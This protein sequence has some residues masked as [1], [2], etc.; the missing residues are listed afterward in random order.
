MT[1]TIDRLVQI[2]ATTII[3]REEAEAFIDAA[4]EAFGPDRAEVWVDRDRLAGLLFGFTT[5][6]GHRW[7]RPGLSHTAIS[8]AVDLTVIDPTTVAGAVL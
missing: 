1:A 4:V 7:V 8:A 3:A 6:P 5:D 2:P